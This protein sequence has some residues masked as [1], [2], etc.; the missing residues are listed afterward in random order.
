[1]LQN[2]DIYVTKYTYEYNQYTYIIDDTSEFRWMV[3]LDG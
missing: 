2:C 1:M 3:Y